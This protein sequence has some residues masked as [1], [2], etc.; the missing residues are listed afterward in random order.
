[1]VGCDP[2]LFLRKDDS[3]VSAYGLI[4]GTKA[5]PH[6][7]RSGA[8]QVDGM[9][10]E[11]NIE[12]A[13]TLRGFKSRIK[14]VR[15]QLEAMLEGYELVSSPIA[16]FDEAYMRS[17]PEEALELGCDPDYN[18][19]TG[20]ANER[21]N[22]NV[23]FR[24]AGGHV[25]IGWTTDAPLDHPDHVEACRMLTR[26]LD[27]YL[28]VP[29]LFWDTEDGRRAMYGKAGAFRSKSY[30]VEYRSLSNAWLA[31]DDIMGFV[32]KQTQKAF[33]NLVDGHSL[34]NKSSNA[35]KTAVDNNDREL[36]QAIL[37]HEGAILDGV[38]ELFARITGE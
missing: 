34:Y 26:E 1:M 36:A 8:V 9:A 15:R 38:E 7:V 37:N 18:A 3:F 20:E 35:A 12:P 32:F 13:T 11:F 5:D 21:P 16:H 31:D 25:H 4:P 6:R 28:G 2:E 24:T 33:K 17:Q 19:Y 27:F 23:S 10:V 30:G 29:S 14:A 22:G